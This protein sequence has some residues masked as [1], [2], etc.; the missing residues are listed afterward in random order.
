VFDDDNK[1]RDAASNFMAI[2]MIVIL[3]MVL[4][5][6]ILASTLKEAN[7][8]SPSLCLDRDSIITMLETRYQ[9]ARV[10]SGIVNT[11]GMLIEVFTSEDGSTWTIISTTPNG[12]TCILTAGEAWQGYDHKLTRKEP[13]A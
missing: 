4:V 3:A 9:E 6:I 8:Q 10:S 12:Y 11:G 7:A 5:F 2:V 13:Q 1:W